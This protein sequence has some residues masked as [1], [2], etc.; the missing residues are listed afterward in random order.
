MEWTDEDNR[1]WLA[2]LGITDRARY[3]VVVDLLRYA[4]ERTYLHK[5]T[6]HEEDPRDKLGRKKRCSCP[7]TGYE[8]R[9]DDLRIVVQ[10][11]VVLCQ[12]VG[13]RPLSWP[14]EILRRRLTKDRR[15]RSLQAHAQMSDRQGGGKTYDP[16]SYR[17]EQHKAS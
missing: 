8:M 7:Q 16:V 2:S 17:D 5:P 10:A 1:T 14:N 9:T 6:C 4:D 13:E 15:R 12:R 11:Y 3:D